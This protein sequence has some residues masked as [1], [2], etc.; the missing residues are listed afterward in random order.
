M[1]FGDRDTAAGDVP[2]VYG[3]PLTVVSA[4]V[5]ALMVKAYILLLELLAVYANLPTEAQFTATAVMLALA[6][7]PLPLV[8]VHV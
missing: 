4:P 1:P 8:T 6:V 5:V 2:S 7:V 3:L